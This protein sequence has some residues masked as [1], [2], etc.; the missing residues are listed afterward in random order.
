MSNK[1]A[2]ANVQRQLKQLRQEAA[3]PRIPLSK[4]C[5]DLMQFCQ[6]HQKSDILVTGIN[7]SENPYK[8]TKG[9]VVL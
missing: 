2:I 9:C 1:E 4:A 6:E 8:E 7:P 3:T 5:S